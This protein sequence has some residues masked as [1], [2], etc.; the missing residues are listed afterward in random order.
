MTNS[1]RTFKTFANLNEEDN[2]SIL[3][4]KILDTLKNIEAE[5]P[6][7][8]SNGSDQKARTT[9]NFFNQKKPELNFDLEQFLYHN[10]PQ[11]I[12]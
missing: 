6:L 5:L 10:Q 9:Q 12:N 8:I 4:L 1:T 11:T 2:R 7:L 3:F